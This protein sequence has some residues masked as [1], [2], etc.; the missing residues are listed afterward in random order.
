MKTMKKRE[1]DRN[2]RLF[3]SFCDKVDLYRKIVDIPFL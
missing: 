3:I 1:I 2:A